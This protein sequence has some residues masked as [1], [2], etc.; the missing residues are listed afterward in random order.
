M[1]LWC[2]MIVAKGQCGQPAY[3]SC[4][5]RRS[6]RI[7]AINVVQARIM[8]ALTRISNM[9][10]CPMT[11]PLW[12]DRR[13]EG[14]TPLMWSISPEEARFQLRRMRNEYERS[15]TTPATFAVQR[16]TAN[17]SAT[18]KRSAYWAAYWIAKFITTSLI[19]NG[20]HSTAEAITL[21]KRC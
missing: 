2:V 14:V 16:S 13:I 21:P 8:D 5:I 18:A 19:T 15:A 11:E 17:A 7:A 3:N 10:R 6:I 4:P 9:K 1:F 12:T 20:T